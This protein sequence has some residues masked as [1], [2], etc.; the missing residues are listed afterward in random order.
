MAAQ[1]GHQ[2][3]AKPLVKTADTLEITEIHPN[4]EGFPD[5]VC[6]RNKA[7]IARVQGVI[8]VVAHGKVMSLWHL[9][10]H[11]FNRVC[12]VIPEGKL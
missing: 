6:F 1:S 11:S 2:L 5:N 8:A 9:A 7:L 10:R 4:E 3:G 12:A